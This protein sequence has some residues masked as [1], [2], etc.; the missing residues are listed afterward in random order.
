[1]GLDNLNRLR[2][3]GMQTRSNSGNDLASLAREPERDR[4][5]SNRP[6]DKEGPRAGGAEGGS[7]RGG[8]RP[9]EGA[10]ASSK[11]SPLGGRV[12]SGSGEGRGDVAGDGAV[13]QVPQKS[14]AS[15]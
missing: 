5:S 15:S 9:R 1:M 12:R 6:S 7:S 4:N 8:G 13:M 14:P 2:P 11:H 3:A 10:V